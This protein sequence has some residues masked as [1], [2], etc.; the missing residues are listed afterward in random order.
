MTS[1]TKVEVHKS[2][3]S[4]TVR[5]GPGHGHRQHA[6]KI[7]E[8]QPCGCRVMQADTLTDRQTDLLISPHNTWHL[9][10]GLMTAT[11]AN[12]YAMLLLLITKHKIS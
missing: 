4:N 1:C 5:E 9:S 3:Y 7:G 8:V 10:Q 2:T 12:S 6:E 11:F